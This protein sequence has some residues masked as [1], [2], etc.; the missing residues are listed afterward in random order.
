LTA[1]NDH[2]IGDGS[3]RNSLLHKPIKQQSPCSCVTT[4]EPEGE[5]IEVIIEVLVL[6]PTL[7]C[8]V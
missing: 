4:I 1:A 2:G 6:N 5:L 7:V 8:P 3:N